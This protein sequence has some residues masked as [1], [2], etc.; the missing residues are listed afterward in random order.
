VGVTVIEVAHLELKGLRRI[1]TV[2]DLLLD[3]TCE[4]T[5]LS[6]LLPALLPA[7]QRA[8][9]ADSVVCGLASAGRRE[10]L[11]EPAG[12][13]GHTELDEF[14][15]HAHEDPLVAHTRSGPGWPVRRSDLQTRLEYRA[16]GTYAHVYRT[17]GADHQ[18]A[19]SLPAASGRHAC[20]AFNRSRAD[21]DDDDVSV[22]DALRPRLAMVMT[23]LEPPR[24][25]GSLTAR[26][27]EVLDLLSVGADNHHIAQRMGIS[28]RTVDKHLE[29]AY[30]KL[31]AHGLSRV[32]VARRWLTISDTGREEM[33]MS[34]TP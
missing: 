3:A 19:L 4:P 8:I 33:G 28:S 17:L 16:L 32:A 18:L 27:T 30:T 7:L 20:F 23:R 1:L 6:S 9:P 22:A 2:V 14:E 21:F 13:L 15:R 5:P 11:T 31:G 34:T 25:H 12:L 24:P 26:E 29:H 10:V